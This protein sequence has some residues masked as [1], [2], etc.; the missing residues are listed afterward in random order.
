MQVWKF[1]S[2]EDWKCFLIDLEIEHQI[3]IKNRGCQLPTLAIWTISSLIQRLLLRQ[4]KNA[5]HPASE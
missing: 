4:R 1:G 3:S 2:M 5:I